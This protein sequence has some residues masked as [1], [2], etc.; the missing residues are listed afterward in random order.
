MFLIIDFP[1]FLIPTL[2]P[3]PA[4]R[5]ERSTGEK[6][7]TL[8]VNDRSLISG[9]VPVSISYNLIIAAFSVALNLCLLIGGFVT[10][11]LNNIA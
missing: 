4:E 5:A 1:D 11:S 2:R 9:L 3:T 10:L 6:I 8:M 7:E